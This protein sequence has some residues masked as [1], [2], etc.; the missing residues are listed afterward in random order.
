MLGSGQARSCD[1]LPDI[2]E[3][4]FP[5]GPI[6]LSRNFTVG[7]RDTLVSTCVSS[8]GTVVPQS[9]LVRGRV[10]PSQCDG[11][12]GYLVFGGTPFASDRVPDFLYLYGHTPSPGGRGLSGRKGQLSFGLNFTYGG[13]GEV[14]GVGTPLHPDQED[15]FW[16]VL[17]S[18]DGTRRG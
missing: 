4:P 13:R 6:I 7:R 11:V 15:G 2:P 18:E 14:T 9:C 1:S 12:A 3:R 8:V 5:R 17:G 16:G 10:P